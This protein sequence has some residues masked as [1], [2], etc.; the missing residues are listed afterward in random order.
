MGQLIGRVN[1]EHR[2]TMAP[3][4]V[5]GYDDFKNSNSRIFSEIYFS[6]CQS[7][8]TIGKK[9]EAALDRQLLAERTCKR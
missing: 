7:E 4:M 8:I 9:E 6:Q 2:K 1:V 5:G 3:T